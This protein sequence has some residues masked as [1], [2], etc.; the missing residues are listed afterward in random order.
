MKIRYTYIDSDK[1]LEEKLSI[2]SKHETVGVDTETV[3]P[4][5]EDALDPRRGKIRLIQISSPQ[6]EVLLI[7]CFK[8]SQTSKYLVKKFLE[9]PKRVKVLYNAKFDIKFLLLNGIRMSNVMDTMLLAGVLEAGLNNSLKLASV[10]S[11]YLGLEIS[12]DEQTSNWGADVLSESQLMYSAID[13]GILIPIAD[14]L[15]QEVEINGLKETLNLELEALPAIAEM[16]LLGIKADVNKL[17]LLK[18]DLKNKQHA[19]LE[20]LQEIFGSEFN[21]QSPKQLKKALSA[22]NICVESTAKDVLSKLAPMHKEIQTVLDYKEV[23][24]RLEFADKIPLAINASTGRI[25]SNYFQL[26]TATGR[27]SCTNFNLQQVPHIKPFREC[28]IP[29]E[30]NVFVISDYSQMQIRIAADYSQ[31]PVMKDIYQKGEDLHRITASILTGKDISE[32]SS[33]ERSLAKAL[34]FGMMFG[35]GAESLVSYTWKNYHVELLPEEASAFI[36]KFYEKYSGFK[37]WQTRISNESSQATRTMLGRRRLFQGCG[38]YTQLINS[39]IQGVEA[40]VLKTVLGKLATNLEG[41]SGQLVATIHDEIIVECKEQEGYTVVKIV[42]ETMEK[43]GQ[44][45]LKTI[46][47]VADASVAASWADK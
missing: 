26:G 30:G 35:M 1:L 32:I 19:L 27:L 37:S 44:R 13:A 46:P 7:D 31:D 40:D 43:A 6:N 3:G 2:F 21:P 34:N 14:V 22:I 41:T 5:K 4:R 17:N 8:I 23:S 15:L 24:K 11:R 42:K 20:N 12:K 39:P 45:F 18:Q 25:H 16:E 33:E 10:A 28:F 29:E 36:S 47:V 38:N 9:N